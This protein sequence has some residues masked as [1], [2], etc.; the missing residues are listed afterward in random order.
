MEAALAPDMFYHLMARIYGVPVQVFGG[1]GAPLAQY[2]PGLEHAE[3]LLSFQGLKERLFKLCAAAQKPQILSSEL[4]QL[5]AGIPADEGKPGGG[6]IVLGPVFTS[7]GATNIMLDYVR[8]YNIAPVP[9]EKLLAALNQS[10]VCAYAEFTRL[11]AV[12][13]AFTSGEELDTTDLPIAGLTEH[14]RS[15]AQNLRLEEVSQ[16][17]RES[18]PNPTYALGQRL[19]ECVREGSLEK[20]KRLLKTM[21]YASIHYLSLPDPIRQQKDMFISLIAQVVNA[22]VEGGL[23]PEAAYSL[24]D[25][26]IQQVEAMKNMIPIISLTREMLYDY[27]SRVGRLKRTGRYS[28]LINDCCSYINEHVYENIHVTDVAEFTGHNAHYLAQR[29][30]AE[31]GQSISSYIREAKISEAKTL[32]KYT[33]MPL[34]EISEQLAF[35]SQSFFTAA[36]RQAA[37][38]TPGRFREE[39]KAHPA[40]RQA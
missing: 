13:F 4:G 14:E 6:L 31:T 37:G 15:A 9:R 17:R 32:L 20:L 25:R 3:F 22:A 28:S 33:D 35:S 16:A 36:F 10:P 11:T 18:A 29:F 27:T 5:W 39:C 40:A 1:P 21:N 24:N 30:R 26:Y 7:G 38:V 8:S 23:D 34:A 19:L 2:G 12:L